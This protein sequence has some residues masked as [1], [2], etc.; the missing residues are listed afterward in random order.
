MS[1]RTALA[2]RWHDLID[3]DAGGI[4]TGKATL[5]ETGW[6]IFRFALDVASGRRTWAE[7]WGLGNTLTPFHPA[8]VT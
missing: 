7:Q 1:S 2:E 8:P 6:E 4:A 3:V 5:Q